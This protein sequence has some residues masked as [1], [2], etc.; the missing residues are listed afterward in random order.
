MNLAY[1]WFSGSGIF[2][3]IL[4]CC[5]LGLWIVLFDSWWHHQS[6]SLTDTNNLLAIFLLSKFCLHPEYFSNL[7]LH[8]LNMTFHLN[9]LKINQLQWKKTIK[10][11]EK[12]YYCQGFA[13]WSFTINYWRWTDCGER[14]IR[15]LSRQDRWTRI[16]KDSLK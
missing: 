5:K 6:K 2:P 8:I 3:K 15:G 7:T 9:L 13:G 4:K 14:W 16:F 12:Q 10:P 11:S 1:G